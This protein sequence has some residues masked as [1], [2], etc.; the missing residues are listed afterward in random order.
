MPARGC[1]CLRVA[2]LKLRDVR[3][4]VSECELTRLG[5]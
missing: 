2:A 5:L 4:G 1:V 3:G